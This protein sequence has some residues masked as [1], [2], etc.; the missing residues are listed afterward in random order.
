MR[1]DNTMSVDEAQAV[2]A[3]DKAG[4]VQLKCHPGTA[5]TAV[6]G[7]FANARAMR[8]GGIAFTYLLEGDLSRLRIPAQGTGGAVDGLWQHT[9]FEAFVAAT[10]VAGY[11]EFNFAPSGDWAVYAFSR[12]REGLPATIA[13]GPEI[14]VHIEDGRLEVEALVA[15]EHLLQE[16]AAAGWR[17]AL[18]AVIEDAAGVLSYWAL[19]H[20]PGKPDFH[21]PDGFALALRTPLPFADLG[22]ADGGKE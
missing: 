21:H 8:D 12:Y 10:G 4:F 3:A 1:M 13:Q 9:C 14:T 20:L 19:E 11:R 6:H 7:L 17:I 16:G 22:A 15:R 2:T 18:S 5:T